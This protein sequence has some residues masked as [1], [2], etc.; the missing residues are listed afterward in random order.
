[1][2]IDYR[3]KWI[4]IKPNREKSLVLCASTGKKSPIKDRPIDSF[5][6]EIVNGQ[7][8]VRINTYTPLG[9]VSFWLD[10]KAT[11]ELI[12]D[13][14]DCDFS[15]LNADTKPKKNDTLL[16]QQAD[17]DIAAIKS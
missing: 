14:K 9:C 5:L 6:W 3:F 1:M 11:A 8:W 2:T 16:R 13:I 7:L 17:A 15:R 10:K 4:K 12:K